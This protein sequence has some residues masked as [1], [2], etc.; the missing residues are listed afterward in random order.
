MLFCF[1][2]IWNHTHSRTPNGLGEAPIEFHFFLTLLKSECC[3]GHRSHFSRV[4]FPLSGY[5]PLTSQP[6][7]SPLAHLRVVLCAMPRTLLPSPSSCSINVFVYK[8]HKPLWLCWVDVPK[9]WLLWIPPPPPLPF[10]QS[11]SSFGCLHPK[12]LPIQF[13]SLW[14][15]ASLCL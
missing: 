15:R 11:L 14:P 3:T 13:S 5:Q 1:D 8:T 4:L 6:A 9:P 2:A 12:H 10:L 7:S